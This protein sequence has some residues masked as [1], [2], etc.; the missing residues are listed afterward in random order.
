MTIVGFSELHLAGCDTPPQGDK[1]I[2]RGLRWS[3][4]GRER[5]AGQWESGLSREGARGHRSAFEILRPI[6]SGSYTDAEVQGSGR[7]QLRNS[8]VGGGGGG[9]GGVWSQNTLDPKLWAWS[10][11]GCLLHFWGCCEPSLGAPTAQTAGPGWLSNTGRPVLTAH[12]EQCPR[13]CTPPHPSPQTVITNNK[14]T[15]IL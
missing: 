15:C 11:P 10:H 12:S 6:S 1:T 4:G 8:L 13:G 14:I 2:G 5:G 9:E 7:D 3:G